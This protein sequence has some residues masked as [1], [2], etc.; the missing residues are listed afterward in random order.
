MTLPRTLGALWQRHRTPLLLVL[1]VF[2]LGA[3]YVLNPTQYAWAPKCPFKLITGWSCPGCGIQRC[4]HALLHG[5]WA[6]ALHYNYF[7]VYSVPYFLIVAFTEWG[8]PGKLQQGLRR[9]FEGHVAITL[10]I[11]LF[12]TWGILRNIIGL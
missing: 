12:C 2:V 10:Y 5:H 8:A 4:L 3:L 6:E 9:V 7:L 11:L 1:L